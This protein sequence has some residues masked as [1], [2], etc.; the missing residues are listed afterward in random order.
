MKTSFA[1]LALIGATQAGYSVHVNIDENELQRAAGAIGQRVGQ[2]AND[3][4]QHIMPIAGSVKTVTEEWLTKAL[5]TEDVRC[6]AFMRFLNAIKPAVYPNPETCNQDAFAQCLIN[7]DSI[8]ILK[9]GLPT[10]GDLIDLFGTQCAVTN[11]CS[12]PCIV[13]GEENEAFCG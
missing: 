4:G 10:S 13:M 2:W 8:D 7:D 9:Y 12:A 6:D 11:G 5:A 1:V 3:N